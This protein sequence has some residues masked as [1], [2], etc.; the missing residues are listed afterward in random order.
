MAVPTEHEEQVQVVSWCN[1]MTDRGYG[2]YDLIYAIANGGQRGKAQAGKLKAEG[3]K[4][5]VPDLCLPVPR[6]GYG[7]LYIEMKREKGGQVRKTQ[8]EYMARLTRAG[9][10]CVVC[11]GAEEAKVAIIEYMGME[12]DKDA[13]R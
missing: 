4:K 9:N 6:G 13:R 1:L 11:R 2:D 12:A 3:V 8:S 10:L 7:A 5:G